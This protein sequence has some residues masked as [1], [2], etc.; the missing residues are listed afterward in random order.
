MKTRHVALESTGVG[1]SLSLSHHT[2]GPPSGRKALYI[3]A[4]LHAGEVP[5]LL[6]LQHLLATL[7]QLEKSDDLLHQVTVSAWANPIGMA[8]HLM[9]HLTGRFDLGG[10]GNFDRNF[11]D[12]GSMINATFGAPGPRSLSHAEIKAWLSQAVLDLLSSRNPV[13]ALKL[14]L[15]AIGFEHDSVL[16]L[17][18][19]KTA[20]MHIY[21]SWEY[22]ERARALARCMGA[23]VLILE[24]DAGGG[25]FDQ[26]F[27]DA[28]RALKS[29]GVCT[30]S[31]IGFAAVA[32]LRG[33][34][35]VCDELAAAD[36]AGLVDFLRTEGI[37][38]SNTA[39]I[40]VREPQIVALN[41]VS[42]VT[43]PAAGVIAWNA[44]CGEQIEYG[45]TIAEI[46]ACDGGVPTKRMHVKANTSGVLVAHAHIPLATPGQRI[47]MIAGNTALPDRTSG[48]LLHD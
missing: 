46:V 15:L 35:D 13:Q 31:S 2:F 36:A 33:Q 43:A 6:V 27:R 28:W 41:A 29:L 5:G 8:Q 45:A 14:Q 22:Q 18:C 26:A 48:K 7:T 30:D 32:E 20:I 1:T 24:D 44:E 11:Y 16:D 17:H 9:G 34:R 4:A 21:S 23:P 42:H 37:V 19:D 38:R 39:P 12:V 10:T 47:A 25:T 40:A 3:Q